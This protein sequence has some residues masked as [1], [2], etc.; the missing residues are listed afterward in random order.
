MKFHPNRTMCKWSNVQGKFHMGRGKF[1]GQ[2]SK[3]KKTYKFPSENE[4]LYEVSSKSKI[5]KFKGNIFCGGIPQGGGKF[6]GG[7]LKKKK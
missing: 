4:S 2:I 6:R 3:K 1:G 7:F 5:F